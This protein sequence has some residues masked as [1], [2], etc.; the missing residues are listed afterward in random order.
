MRPS[1]CDH[2]PVNHGPHLRAVD[3]ELHRS[4]APV[5]VAVDGA[6]GA[7]RVSTSSTNDASAA[8][9]VCSVA[10]NGAPRRTWTSSDATVTSSTSSVPP[11]VGGSASASNN[12]ASTSGKLAGDA[13]TAAA[14]CT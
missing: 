6:R 11:P 2:L 5:G 7:A 10:V 14:A 9:R 3:D 13:S 1:R 12:R 8:A 4:P